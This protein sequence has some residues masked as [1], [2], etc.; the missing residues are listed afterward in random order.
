MRTSRI[1]LSAIAVLLQVSTAGAGHFVGSFQ[2]EFLDDGR[3]IRLLQ[4]YEFDDDNNKQWNVPSGTE[5][6]GASIPKPLWSIIGGPFE[7]KYRNAS[8]IHDY[9]C[10]KETTP[11]WDVH[12]MFYDAMIA[13]DVG[14]IEAEILYLG[15]FNFGPRWTVADP[16]SHVRVCTTGINGFTCIMEFREGIPHGYPQNAYSEED[17]AKI[18]AYVRAQVQGGD[19]PLGRDADKVLTRILGHSSIIKN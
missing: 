6:D 13:S 15:V 11:W 7:G 17:M 16:P 10:D 1:I 18:E 19:L 12:Q 8:V 3:K 9:E 5:V 14:P 2:A 4:P